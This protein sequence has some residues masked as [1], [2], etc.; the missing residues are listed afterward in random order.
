MNGSVA[1]P[2]QVYG[3]LVQG[4]EEGILEAFTVMFDKVARSEPCA[5]AKRRQ[6]G[7]VAHI[8]FAGTVE[9]TLSLVFPRRTAVKM[10]EKLVGQ[11]ISF[12]SPDMLDMAGELVNIVAGPIIAA[13]MTQGFEATMGLPSVTTS[14]DVRE[15]LPDPL[16]DGLHFTSK[17]GPF[18]AKIVAAHTA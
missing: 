16:A 14:Q 13:L 2:A 4:V 18:R 9:W 10:A 6:S 1:T 12:A 3:R 8:S 15:V 7:M 5:K 11:K 17:Q